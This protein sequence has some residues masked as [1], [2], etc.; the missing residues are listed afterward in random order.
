[1]RGAEEREINLGRGM[2]FARFRNP[3]VLAVSMSAA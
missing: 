1:M 2:M 3:D